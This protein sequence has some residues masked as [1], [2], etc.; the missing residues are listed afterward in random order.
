MKTGIEQVSKIVEVP[1]AE[2]NARQMALPASEI[3]RREVFVKTMKDE[4]MVRKFVM[5]KTNKGT[6]I[7]DYPSFVVHYT[8]FSPNRKTPL[9]RDVRIS[10][11]QE[12]IQ[13]LW[14][15]LKD[16]NIKKGWELHAAAAP[17]VIVAPEPSVQEEPAKV[18]SAKKPRLPRKTAASE[19][20]PTKAPTKKKKSG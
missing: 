11:S 5:W 1:G 12:Q 9:N 13:T 14:S 2:R 7:E 4:T 8:D 19:E 17:D 10:S 3:L 18:P 16:A 20:A 15:E 6:E